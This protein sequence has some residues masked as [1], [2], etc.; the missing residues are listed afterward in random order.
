MSV[1]FVFDSYW[2]RVWFGWIRLI[3]CSCFIPVE[4]GWLRISFGP[5]SCLI[6]ARFVSRPRFHVYRL[7]PC[8]SSHSKR[9]SERLCD[10]SAAFSVVRAHREPS[11]LHHNLQQHIHNKLTPGVPSWP[12]SKVQ[13]KA[14]QKTVAYPLD[15]Q[16]GA[17]FD[18]SPRSK[19]ALP[20]QSRMFWRGASL[21]FEKKSPLISLKLPSPPTL[22]LST[23]H[24]SVTSVHQFRA[25]VTR[26]E[27]VEQF[28][29]GNGTYW[30]SWS[31]FFSSNACFE[32]DE[33]L[34]NTACSE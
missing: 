24:E 2:V 7:R 19:L 20:C 27:T 34:N 26:H 25:N 1:K 21:R 33:S 29:W 23:I 30:K 9:V 3:F 12:P 31:K 5:S 4:S 22:P 6:R 10:C 11:V 32:K 16:S 28:M 18:A 13:G 15:I 8:Y 17:I 14:T